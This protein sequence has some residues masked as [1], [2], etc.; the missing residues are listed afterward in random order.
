MTQEISQH[1]DSL[2]PL[3][4]MLKQHDIWADKKFGQNFLFDLNLTQKI[5]RLCEDYAGALS[6]LNILEVGPGPGGLTRAIL[7]HNPKTFTAIEMDPRFIELLS[8]MIAIDDTRFHLIQGDALDFKVSDWGDISDNNNAVIA[9]LPYNVGTPLL[10]DWLTHAQHLKFIAVMLQKEVTDRIIAKPES[11]AYGRLGVL[12]QYLCLCAPLI[13]VPAS[14]FT[15][16]PKVESAVIYLE[17]KKDVETRLSTLPFLEKVTQL[18]F[19]QRRKMVRSS[20][21]PLLNNYPDMLEVCGI[22]ETKRAE[23]LSIDDFVKLAEFIKEK[24]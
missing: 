22:E 16:A 17:P 12:C 20:L 6:E 5:V 24:A 3:R 2:P 13:K 11:K 9:N 19:G 4:E 21:K 23:N 10:I 8:P 18:A 15:P 7:R 14:A 1:I